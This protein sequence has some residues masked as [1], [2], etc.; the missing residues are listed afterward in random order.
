MLLS[1]QGTVFV[2]TENWPD[3][4]T[5]ERKAAFLTM[6]IRAQHKCIPN[7]KD[8]PES[9]TPPEGIQPE[10]EEPQAEPR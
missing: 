2:G 6:N 9:N 7:V 5:C 10:P 3:Q 8:V 1:L 4:A